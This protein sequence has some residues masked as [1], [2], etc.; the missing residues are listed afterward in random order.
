MGAAGALGV[1]AG[2]DAAGLLAACAWAAGVAAGTGADGVAAAAGFAAVS[3]KRLEEANATIPA[4]NTLSVIR[5]VRG[6]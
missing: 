3:A 1:A 2:L 4:H 6:I 5:L